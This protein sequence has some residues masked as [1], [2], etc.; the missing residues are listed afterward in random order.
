MQMTNSEIV[1]RYKAADNWRKM[2][3]ILAE[4]NACPKEEIRKIL[5]EAG[6][7][8]PAT[9][10]R[11]TAAKKE[12]EET[13][14]SG[15]KRKKK[16]ELKEAVDN[17][18]VGLN[19]MV[20]DAAEG[21]NKATAKDGVETAETSGSKRKQAKL[22]EKGRRLIKNEESTECSDLNAPGART[23]ES[24]YGLLPD[25]DEAQIGWCPEQKVGTMSKKKSAPTCCQPSEPVDIWD[26]D[27]IK[28]A[29]EELR[30]LN[31][32]IEAMEQDVKRKQLEIQANKCKA[33][34]L[35]QWILN[36]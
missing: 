28:Y 2:I 22:T 20:R 25:A 17:I 35:W 32:L 11:Y 10:N 24:P 23:A 26:E 9:G 16:T 36:A 1:R 29:K 4:L 12:E 18:S 19:A 14:A 6:L 31:E 34:Y 13:E 8:V 5:R 30:R 21:L 15:S 33:E 3:R 27:T 7:D